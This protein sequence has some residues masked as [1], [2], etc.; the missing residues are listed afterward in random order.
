MSRKQTF[1]KRNIFFYSYFKIDLSQIIAYIMKM[2]A[3]KISHD[4]DGNLAQ[5]E[6]FT[7]YAKIETF[8][9]VIP[10]NGCFRWEI[11]S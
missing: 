8:F 2:Q 6:T 10:L 4:Y 1:F 5:K 3:T 7:K 9:R 11:K